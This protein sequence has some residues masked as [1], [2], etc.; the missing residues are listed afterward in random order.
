MAVSDAGITIPP[1]VVQQKVQSFR[2]HVQKMNQACQ[3]VEEIKNELA[4]A[5]NSESGRLYRKKMEEW[6]AAY[7]TVATKFNQTINGLE[8]TNTQFKQVE[9]L[10]TGLAGQMDATL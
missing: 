9:E 1:E 3:R 6:M 8:A 10:N 7:S 5:Q 2:D 4:G